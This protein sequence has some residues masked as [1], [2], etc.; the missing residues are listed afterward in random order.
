M[1][2]CTCSRYMIKYIYFI[3]YT[4]IIYTPS[5]WPFISRMKGICYTSAALPPPSQVH[6]CIICCEVWVC[7]RKKCRCYPSHAPTREPKKWME[8]EHLINKGFWFLMA[9]HLASVFFEG[10]ILN[11]LTFQ[12]GCHNQSFL[13]STPAP[14]PFSWGHHGSTCGNGLGSSPANGSWSTRGVVF[15]NKKRIEGFKLLLLIFHIKFHSGSP[16]E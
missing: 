8:K 3:K 11:C 6:A 16:N 1:I 12:H 15:S 14:S 13:G 9:K 5:H 10:V 4:L 7:L 2:I